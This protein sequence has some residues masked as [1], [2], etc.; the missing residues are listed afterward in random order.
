MIECHPLK[1]DP[2]VIPGSEVLTVTKKPVRINSVDAR[3]W[4]NLKSAE[5]RLRKIGPGSELYAAT[6]GSDPVLVQRTG[7]LDAGRGAFLSSATVARRSRDVQ[8]VCSALTPMRALG[9]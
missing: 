3:P 5:F 8:G 1:G 9:A 6:S 4:V 7:W 2:I